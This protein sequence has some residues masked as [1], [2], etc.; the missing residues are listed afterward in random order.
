[1]QQEVTFS[2]V[3]NLHFFQLRTENITLFFLLL[4]PILTEGKGTNRTACVFLEC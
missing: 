3:R 1:M 2:E 4:F